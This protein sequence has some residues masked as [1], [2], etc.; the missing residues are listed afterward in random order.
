LGVLAY[1]YWQM[2]AAMAKKPASSASPKQAVIDALMRLAADQDWDDI[3]LQ[4]IAREADISL[5]DLREHFPSKGAIL[6]A[7]AKQIDRI[8]LEADASDMAGEPAKDRF[9][10]V[11][12]RRFDALQPYKAAIRN[13][14]KAMRRNPGLAVQLN[15]TALNSFRYMLAA[16]DIETEDHLAPVRIQGAVVIFAKALDAWLDDEDEGLAKTMAVLDK[17]LKRGITTMQR[18]EDLDRLMA[19][20]RGFCRVAM[21]RRK[22]RDG[23]GSRMRDFAEQMRSGFGGRRRKRDDD[24]GEGAAI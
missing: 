3:T 9:L 12:M 7:F 17:E 23:L 8:V 14:R 16:A 22:D 11:L 5:A 20:L 15:P 24:L 21:E 13:I 6:G 10:D 19:P 1:L 2:E 4:A 18:F